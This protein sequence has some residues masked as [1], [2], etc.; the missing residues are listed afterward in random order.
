MYKGES[1]LPT[2][3]TTDLGNWLNLKLV[4]AIGFKKP[5]YIALERHK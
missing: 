3:T 4:L 5:N 1:L 2:T